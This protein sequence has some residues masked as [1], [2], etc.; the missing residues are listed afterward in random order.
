MS[1]AAVMHPAIVTD[2]IGAFGV[3]L[4]VVLVAPWL[5]ARLK[6]PHIVGLII[7]GFVIGPGCCNLVANTAGVT[8]LSKVGVLYLM[9]LAGLE[10][11]MYHLRRNA[12]RGMVFGLLTLFLPMAGGWAA[13]R[14]LLGLGPWM[15]MLVGVIFA[16]NTLLSYPMVSRYGIQKTAPV[17]MAV[18]GTI[19]AVVGA[20][21]TL[22]VVMDAHSLGGF[23]LWHLARLCLYSVGYVLI[24]VWL[25]PRLARWYFKRQASRVN[26]WIF[27]MVLLVASALWAR[28]IGLDGIIGAFLAGIVLNR[29]VPWSSPLMASIE[30]VGN[31]LFI[32]FF[33]VT[34][35]MLVDVRAVGAWDT[36]L[37][38]AVLTIAAVAAKWLPAWLARRVYGVSSDGAGVM[39]GLTVAH[40]AVA[41][42]VV[43]LGAEAGIFD[44]S[45][46]GAVVLLILVTCV[47]APVLT[48]GPA[49]RMK[50]DAE[51]RGRSSAEDQEEPLLMTAVS[52]PV[53]APS[54]VEMAMLLHAPQHPLTAVYIRDTDSD[55]ARAHSRHT[56]DVARRVGAS[57]NVA[58]DTRERYDVNRVTGL[59][60]A[61]LEQRARALLIGMHQRAG[62]GDSAWGQTVQALINAYSGTIAMSRMYIP[63]G[64]IRRIVV[65]MPPKAQFES[66]F[67]HWTAML[68][69]LATQVGCRIICCCKQAQRVYVKDAMRR[70]G[71]GVRLEFREMLD[72]DDM[73]ALGRRLLQDDLAILVGAR[74]NTLSYMPAMQQM[75]AYVDRQ[76]ARHNVLIIYP[77][78]MG[79]PT[80][81]PTWSVDP[82]ASDITRAPSPLWVRLGLV[83]RRMVKAKRR[84]TRRLRGR[85]S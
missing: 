23:R 79:S 16:A 74:V 59:V 9:F 82:L 18:M 31:A 80:A 8:T 41:L 60:G 56:L 10:I 24:V 1:A 49:R 47:L 84:F 72:G 11:D 48:S 42:A 2:P 33:L 46:T 58:L 77:G 4:C 5:L 85:N 3:V 34:V 15:S 37:T 29:H 43:N 78:Q 63:A 83:W 19:V 27:V 13:S 21:V 28:A 25:Y 51:R 76:L 50:I 39:W 75:P 44:P 57:A 62:L 66:G 55:T 70:G 7:A 71:F 26:Q 45:M 52:N 81:S 6:V 64:T 35:G 65:F 17:A 69:R 73:E 38:A 61:A 68:G 67:P 36:L 32:P 14:W 40:T 53:T 54:L 20:L 30:M 12:G 22:G